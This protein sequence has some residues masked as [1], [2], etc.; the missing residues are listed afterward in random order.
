MDLAMNNNIAVM[1][2]TVRNL[3][4]GFLSNGVSKEPTWKHI[5]D[6]HNVLLNAKYPE[7]SV[8]AIL[9]KTFSV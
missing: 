5:K 4:L 7:R 8:H 3:M 6:E 1:T 2:T 9:K